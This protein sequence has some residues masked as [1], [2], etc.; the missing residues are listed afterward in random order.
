MPLSGAKRPRDAET[1]RPS[2]KRARVDEDEEV[3][4]GRRDASAAPSFGLPQA[5]ATAPFEF[6]DQSL[7]L[8]DFQLDVPEL[9]TAHETLD[10]RSA[11]PSEHRSS[12]FST[13]ASHFEEEGETFA[14]ASCP[15]A[16]F[17]ARSASQTQQE[18]PESKGYSRNTLKALSIV[19]R[20]LRPTEGEADVDAEG[21]RATEDV[22]ESV[23]ERPMLG[24][25]PDAARWVCTIRATDY[26]NVSAC[27]GRVR[28]W[29]GS[30][31]LI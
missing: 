2:S 29:C 22:E 23:D 17:D 11:A 6:G 4:Q 31:R 24:V 5:D 7:P 21:E 13:P 10:R 27:P 12:R 28:G 1:G 26:V 25:P 16:A 18:A 14:D 19:R 8:D 9:P 3:E 15:I 20:E 30:Y